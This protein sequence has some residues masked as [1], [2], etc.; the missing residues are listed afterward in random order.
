MSDPTQSDAFGSTGE[1]V[2]Y[3]TDDGRAQVQLRLVDGTVWLTQAEMAELFDTGVP[4]INKHI[5][6]ILGDGEL[7][8]DRTISYQEIVRQEGERAVRREVKTYNL[9]MI[10]AVG[11]RVRSPRGVQFRQWATTV[12]S[13]YLVKGFAMNDERL[14]DPV[15]LD[16]FDELLERI[17]DIRSSEKRFYQ[18]V[19]DLFTLSADYDSTSEMAH[20]F[21]ATIQNKLCYAVTGKAAAELIVERADAG[22]PN[23]GLTSFKGG[24]VRKVDI[25]TAKN[26]LTEDELGTLNLL[27]TQFLDFAELRARRRQ[28]TTMTDWLTQTDRFLSLN[29]FDLLDNAG[30]MSSA[31][32]KELVATRYE[33]FDKQRRELEAQSAETEAEEDVKELLVGEGWEALNELERHQKR[34]EEDHL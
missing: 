22:A 21:F 34:A 9:D 29:D 33:A 18:K 15:G 23:M 11:Y 26:Y 17:R 20:R 30:T 14:K 7:L 16:Y 13:E 32:M 27:V 6:S 28:S 1:I 24:V 19:R 25:T 8:E 3:N 31:K 4:N 12:L 10:L 2:L 5:N